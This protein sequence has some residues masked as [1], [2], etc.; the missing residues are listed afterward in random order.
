MPVSQSVA[1][2]LL[3]YGEFSDVWIGE[4]GSVQTCDCKLLCVQGRIAVVA[5]DPYSSGFHGL[6]ELGSV[7][8]E[9]SRP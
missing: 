6:G 7:D 8:G 4:V 9:D 2:Y 3:E 5:M 1:Y